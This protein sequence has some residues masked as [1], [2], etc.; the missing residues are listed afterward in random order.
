M[1]IKRWLAGG[2]MLAV[3]AL[4]AAG[5]TPPKDGDPGITPP[6]STVLAGSNGDIV[7]GNT[8]THGD[9]RVGGAIANDLGPDNQQA[10]HVS[11]AAYDSDPDP[12]PPP[13]PTVRD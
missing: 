3:A 13:T 10:K 1:T 7:I 9:I 11:S 6:A 12:G 4:P 5:I 8:A 2:A